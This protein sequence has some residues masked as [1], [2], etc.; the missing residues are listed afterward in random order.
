M[1]KN[2]FT[3]GKLFYNKRTMVAR[4][5]CLFFKLNRNLKNSEEIIPIKI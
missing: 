2:Y 5:I 4:Q 3:Y 1:E